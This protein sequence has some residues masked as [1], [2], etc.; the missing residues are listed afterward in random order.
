MKKL[1]DLVEVPV[2]KTQRGSIEDIAIED[3]AL[4]EELRPYR[5]RANDPSPEVIPHVS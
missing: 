5:E 2:D 4:F 1:S 3:L